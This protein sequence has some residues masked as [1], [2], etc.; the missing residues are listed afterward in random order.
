MTL[1]LNISKELRQ[2]RLR[3]E[4]EAGNEVL[5]LLGASGCGK[6]MTLKCIAGVETPD[7]GMIELNGRVLFDSRRGINIPPRERRVGYLFQNYALFPHMTVEENI[8]VGVRLPRSE[9][10]AI[11]AEKIRAFFLTGLEKAYPPQLSGG[12]QQRVALARILAS[13]PEIMMLDEPFSALDSYLKWQ[14]EKELMTVISAFHGTT[15]FVSHDRDEAYRLC[16]RVAV[17][18]DGRIDVLRE[19][20]DLMQNPETISAARITGCKNFSR[21][22]RL[23]DRT[24]LASDWGAVLKTAA[25][26][27]PDLCY[28][29]YRAH[30]IEFRPAE[31][32]NLDNVIPCRLRNIIEDTFSSII[33][34]EAEREAGG[35]ATTFSDEFSTLRVE[36]PNK[37][38]EDLAAKYG[39]LPDVTVWVRLLPEKLLPL[40]EPLT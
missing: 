15:L 30:Y 40:R 20:A 22:R 38:W 24:L 8:A 31:D 1:K 5:A 4:F 6:S 28:V 17:L 11:V 34:V 23:D 35:D 21:A 16:S 36:M 3:M 18:H 19:R 13:Q 12:Q 27:P 2:F 9:R 26:L 32:A 29:G 14:T 37:E 7:A 25:D 10:A 33:L 39:I